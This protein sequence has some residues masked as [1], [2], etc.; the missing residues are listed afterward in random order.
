MKT[1]L[2]S[3]GALLVSAAVL[4]MGGGLLSTLIAVRANLE[5]FPVFAIGLMTSGYFAGFI[6]GCLLT[7]VLVKRVGHV[8]VFAALSSLVAAT[9][10]IHALSIYIPLWVFLR[11]IAGFAFAGLYM[12]IESWINEQAPNQMRGQ[13]MSVY[14]M[15]DLTAITAGQFMLTLADPGGFVLFSLVAICISLAIFSNI[16]LEFKSAR[17]GYANVSKPE[18]AGE[19]FAYGGCGVFGCGNVKRGILGDCACICSTARPSGYYGLNLHECCYFLRCLDAISSGLV[20]RQIW[21]SGY[22]DHHFTPLGRSRHIFVAICAPRPNH[23]VN[24]CGFVRLVCH[25]AFWSIRS[26]CQ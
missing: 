19:D 7:P 23:D 20:I 12:L 13:V 14:R 18:K 26:P 22:D 6:A 8:R 4:L 24:R 21:P 25:A 16:C 17:G 11:V 10:L 9:T 5:E 15:V 3:V 1:V 2:S